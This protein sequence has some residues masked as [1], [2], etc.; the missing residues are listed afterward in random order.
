VGRC[1]YT[2]GL[3]TTPAQQTKKGVPQP[4][5]E[6][7]VDHKIRKRDGGSGTPDN[8]EVLCSGCNLDKH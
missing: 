1:F 5:T 8:G 7:Q 2:K 3:E 6:T 4:K